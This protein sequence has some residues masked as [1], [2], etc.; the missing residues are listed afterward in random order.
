MCS[1]DYYEIMN[2]SDPNN[3]SSGGGRQ[4][5]ITLYTYVLESLGNTINSIDNWLQF[6]EDQYGSITVLYK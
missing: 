2:P 1:F 4:L 5:K 6:F 3:D